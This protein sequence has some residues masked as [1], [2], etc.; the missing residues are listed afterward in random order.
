MKRNIFRGLL[1]I[2]AIACVLLCFTKVS[3]SGVFPAAIA[4]P[5]EQISMGLRA[6]SLSGGFGNA[7]AIALYVLISL[8]PIG[9]LFIIRIRRKLN[10]EDGIL[11]PLC[12]VLFG[13]LY[14]M[15]NPGFITEILGAAAKPP[16]GK[17]VLGCMIYS[18]LVGY[19]VLR[20]L[21]LFFTGDI[22]KLERYMIIL[23]GFLNVLFVFLVFGACVS[24]LLASI[25]SLQAGN[26]GNEHL[27]GTSYVFLALQYIINA[28]PYVL[29]IFVV[30]A[31]LHLLDEIRKDRYSDETVAAAEHM[32]RLC[33]I[34]L[35]V[36]TLSN[37]IFNLLQLLF[38]KSLMVVN[39]TVQIPVISILFVLAAL[40]LTRFIIENKQLKDE[41]DQF[42]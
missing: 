11:V 39:S 34:V 17:A 3:F 42:I 24:D 40:L 16:I 13:V 27:L 18:L 1:A 2:E 33:A 19:L 37:V 12:A 30:F 8:L 7:I 31:A 4:F 25:S 29:D 32:S 10:T 22:R 9:V 5:F 41:N 28:L 38:A 6:L 26:N 36:T 35:I 21:R 15:V 20:V 23:L 14:L